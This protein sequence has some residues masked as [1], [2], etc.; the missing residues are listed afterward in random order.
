MTKRDQQRQ[1]EQAFL[2]TVDILV[3]GRSNGAALER[4]MSLLNGSED[5]VDYRVTDG[6]RLGCVIDE[7]IRLSRQ[8]GSGNPEEPNLPDQRLL[9]PLP[10]LG[11]QRPKVV[12]APGRKPET[13]PTKTNKRAAARRRPP[14][15]SK[16]HQ[17]NPGK[18]PRSSGKFSNTSPAA[19]WCGSR[20]SRGAASN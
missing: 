15:K 17:V 2:F 6:L 19:N 9:R 13:A 14:E 3:R 20:C 16:S 4:I 1:N 8:E 11:E 18:F 5:I 12:P 7:A 10:N